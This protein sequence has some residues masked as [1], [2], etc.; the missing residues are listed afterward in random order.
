M[1]LDA[2]KALGLV[3]SFPFGWKGSELEVI[4]LRHGLQDTGNVFLC[5]LDVLVKVDAIVDKRLDVLRQRVDFPSAIDD[6]DG[7]G[8]VRQPLDKPAL[9]SEAF[10]E[11]APAFGRAQQF[12]VRRGEVGRVLGRALEGSEHWRGGCEL[13][14][15]GVGLERVDQLRHDADAGVVGRGR[16]V[17][18]AG[19]SQATEVCPTHP[20]SSPDSDLDIHV[21]LLAH[22]RHGEG[23]A[24]ELKCQLDVLDTA[25]IAR[26]RRRCSQHLHR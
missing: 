11:L 6:I 14:G 21:P 20:A 3:G 17:L 18:R 26:S 24:K 16:G 10:G 19:Q 4:L 8:R 1:H 22:A 5:R 15:E 23:G 7:L 12:G 2:D 13:D 9:A 25:G